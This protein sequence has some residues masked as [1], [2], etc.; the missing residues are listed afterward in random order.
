MLS[1]TFRLGLILAALWFALPVQPVLGVPPTVVNFQGMLSDSSGAPLGGS[2]SVTFSLYGVSF[3]GSPLW[4]ETKSV[5]TD[6]EGRFSVLLGESTPLD[7][8]YFG[9]G[10]R[11]LGITIPPD[12]ELAPR[13]QLVSVPY[14]LRTASIAGAG[15]GQ[16]FGDLDLSGEI[17]AQGPT[18]LIRFQYNT[19]AE[20]PDPTVFHGAFGHVH[21]SGAAYFAHAGA[22]VRLANASEVAVLSRLSASDGDPDSAVVVDTAGDLHVL[23]VLQ[24]LGGPLVVGGNGLV[25]NGPVAVVGGP[26]N[27]NAPVNVNNGAQVVG[28]DLLIVGPRRLV[29]QNLAE[30][31]LE[32]G[33]RLVTRTLS[34]LRVDS[35]TTWTSSARLLTEA[36]IEVEIPGY[37]RVLD[38]MSSDKATLELDRLEIGKGARTMELR[39]EDLTTTGGRFDISADTLGLISPVPIEMVALSLTG[40]PGLAVSGGGGVSVTGGGALSTGPGSPAV[41]NGPSVFNVPI[42]APLQVGVGPAGAGALHVVGNITATGAKLF[43]QDHPQDPSK[44]IHYVALEA[45]EAGT[46][47]RGTATL[48]RG[49]AEIVLPEH[50]GLVTGSAGLTAQI[51]PR[52]PVQSMLYVES[53]SAKRLVVKSSHPQDRDVKFDYLVNGVRLGFEDHQPVV[54]RPELVAR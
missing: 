25:V 18:S 20:L 22:W 32:P 16:V 48:S 42:N 6:S 5:T 38:P 29:V 3:G 36:E 8:S 2:F 4:T 11:Y 17:L 41:F 33:A 47:T 19:F 49:V 15:G 10:P 46:Y 14:A 30:L 50:F 54:D 26:A 52:G 31:E 27:F 35:G 7:E 53:V 23:G 43:V 28:G 12:P 13:Q 39:P 37:L 40:A 44:V 51:T 1:H 24:G 21:D 34:E 9:V 45:G